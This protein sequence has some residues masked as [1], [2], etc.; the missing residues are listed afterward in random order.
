MR[1]V[2]S[3]NP[4]GFL[5]RVSGFNVGKVLAAVQRSGAVTAAS[6]RPGDDDPI[7]I[8]AIT[9]GWITFE[10]AIEVHTVRAGQLIIRDAGNSWRLASSANTA[11]HVITIPRTLFRKPFSLDLLKRAHVA[12][13]ASPE[14][15]LIFDY[16]RMLETAEWLDSPGAA[17]LA[18]TALLAFVVGLM[19]KDPVY[20]WLDAEGTILAARGVIEQHLQDEDLSP[21]LIA[22]RLGI[23]VRTLHRSFSCGDQSVM[24]LIRQ[25]RIEKARADLLSRRSEAAV[26]QVAAKWHFSDASHFIRIFK[27]R[28]GVTPGVYVHDHVDAGS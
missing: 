17:D 1:I 6:G 26:S 8:H 12:D 15:R 24:S 3:A 10:S 4:N 2:Q 9:S 22:H 14:V 28:Y 5:L 16:L 18:E 13:M 19:E 25:L 27:A 23:S 20:H 11:S 21:A 7:V